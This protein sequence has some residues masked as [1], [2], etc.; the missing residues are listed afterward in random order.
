M[1]QAMCLNLAARLTMDWFPSHERDLAT[2]VATMANVTGQMVFSLLPPLIVHTPAQLGR[3][4]LVQW[5][6]G[7]V[8]AAL[9][10]RFLAQRPPSPPSASAALQWAEAEAAA[11]SA[12]SHG[13]G[14][15]GWLAIQ[16]IMHDA[17]MLLSNSNFLL[18]AAGFSVGS[19]TVWAVLILEGQLI[20][21]C[22]YSDR[23]AGA[24]GAALLGTGVMSAFAVGAIMETTK[25][26]VEL[27]R[28]V[29]GAAL[30]A[31]AGVLAAS[32]PGHALR[33]VFAYCALGAALQ[34]LLPLTLEHAA[35]MTFPVPA[36]VS[37]SV[38]FTLANI[39]SG[40][41]V[42][43]LTP[44]LAEPASK[45]CT[46]VFT[47]ASGTVLTFMACG[48]L[49]T[50]LVKRDYRRSSCEHGGGGDGSGRHQ[51]SPESPLLGEVPAAS[52]SY[53]AITDP[54]HKD[55]SGDGLT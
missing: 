18:L 48:V 33:L 19:G 5:I 46:S 55:G 24:A 43:A 39:F 52:S 45:T 7:V 40:F 51:E 29:M 15:A 2:T 6:P 35:E 3:I 47:P 50:L 28:G 14:G 20:T 34:P 11:V 37:T 9:S 49:L 44:L 42:L 8:V 23:L 53:G 10:W 38:L 32:T 12:K 16:T 21:P 13:P 31:T 22:G 54:A 36:D 30:A 17:S 27:Q 25:A 26:Y 41:L 4:M 1:C